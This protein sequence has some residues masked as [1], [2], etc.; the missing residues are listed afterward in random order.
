MLEGLNKEEDMELKVHWL[1]G[2]RYVEFT[3][4]DGNTKLSSGVLDKKEAMEYIKQFVDIVD[5]VNDM[6]D[7]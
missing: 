5:D 6:Q 1:S 7:A 4:N 3:I 2:C